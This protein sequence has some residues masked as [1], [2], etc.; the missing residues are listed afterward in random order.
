MNNVYIKFKEENEKHQY[1]LCD[2]DSMDKI[3]NILV[4]L[5]KFADLVHS[6]VATQIK[7]RLDCEWTEKPYFGDILVE[8]SP[9]YKAYKPVLER[10]TDCQLALSNMLKKPKFANYLKKLLEAESANL[11]KVNRIDILFDRLVDFPRRIIQ[12]LESYLKYLE[13]QSKE[14]TDIQSVLDMFT[15]IFIYSNEDLNKMS[16]FQACLNLQQILLESSSFKEN[17]ANA[18]HPLIKQGPIYK[19]AKRNGELQLRHLAIFTDKLIVSKIEKLSLKKTLKLN[20]KI[21]AADIKLENN[22]SDTDELK[23]RVVIP[24]QNNEFQADRARDKEDWIRAFKK[25]PDLQVIDITDRRTAASTVKDNWDKIGID[26]PI[27]I[28]DSAQEQCSGCKEIFNM[29]KRRHHCR[30][31][32]KLYCNDCSNFNTAVKFTEYKKKVRVCK[33]CFY[34]LDPIYQEYQVKHGNIPPSSQPSNNKLTNY[35]SLQKL[36][37]TLK[38]RSDSQPQAPNVESIDSETPQKQPQVVLRNAN[39]THDQSDHDSSSSS[40][41]TCEQLQELG[42]IL[43]AGDDSKAETSENESISSEEL[44]TMTDQNTVQI[45]NLIIKESVED[46]SSVSFRPIISKP[47]PTADEVAQRK[48][49]LLEESPVS[50]V[51][52]TSQ[53]TRRSTNNSGKFLALN[54][55][56]REVVHSEYGY[57]CKIP[58]LDF[59]AGEG[60]CVEAEENG[61]NKQKWDR[62]YVVLYSDNSIGYCI[63]EK[64]ST[65]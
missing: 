41:L 13:P 59:E 28:K 22:S 37:E 31:C 49:S 6:E 10:F 21:A 64:V 40:S 57:V 48:Q 65:S 45:D 44:D 24:G 50:P 12:L 8:K 35:T 38:F 42:M 63:N 11:E 61:R 51:S 15:S 23:F 47:K 46:G 3:F 56:A 60:S 30:T 54:K 55:F 34:Y 36:K 1:A 19:V 9:Y 39:A 2:K 29:V 20:Y 27:W 53:Q 32:G 14:H 43:K 16:N 5:A 17:I 58:I 7:K 26:P 4:T 25:M 33:M 62:Y 18:E 52:V